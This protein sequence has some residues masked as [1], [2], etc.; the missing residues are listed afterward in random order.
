MASDESADP[1]GTGRGTYKVTRVMD[2]YGIDPAFGDELET[3]W[4]ADPP[5]RESLRSLADRF[6]R[7][8][9]TAAVHEST[10]STVEGDVKNL[11][12]LLTDDDVSSGARTEARARLEDHGI[13][14]E[15]V[16]ADF[17]TYQAI[18][19]YLTEYREAEYEADEDDAAHVDSVVDSLSRLQ[20]R[21][22]AVARRNLAQLRDAGRISLGTFQVVV[23]V[24]V[25]CEDCNTQYDVVELLRQGG[26]ECESGDEG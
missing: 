20:S 15:Q 10:L 9:L 23:S 18:R 25:L 13:D 8:L 26:C 21:V 2:A 3:R 22:H 11:Y 6:N 24:S 1:D 7:R 17:L 4:T 14:V 16:E 19:S 5:E 12:R